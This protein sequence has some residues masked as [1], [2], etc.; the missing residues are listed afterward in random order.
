MPF[1][2]DAFDSAK[3]LGRKSHQNLV[4]AAFAVDFQKVAGLHIIRFENLREGYG[5][6][7]EPS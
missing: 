2:D 5:I 4:L 7:H 1:T 3:E 6:D